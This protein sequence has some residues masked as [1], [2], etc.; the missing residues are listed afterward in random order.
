MSHL[1]LWVD[2]LDNAGV[3]TGE[4]PLVNVEQ[5]RI[6]RVLDGA[7]S[8]T[9]EVPGTDERVARL[10]QNERRVR[11]WADGHTG[12]RMIGGGRIR[13]IRGRHHPDSGW[14]VTLDGPDDLDDLRRKSVLLGREHEAAALSSVVSELVDLADWGASTN[15]SATID[16]RF[17]GASVLKALQYLVSEQGI[18]FRQGIGPN[19]IE[20]GV[21]GE[22]NGITILNAPKDGVAIYTDPSLAYIEQIDIEDDSEDVINWLIPLG[23]GDGESALT[24]EHSTRTSPYTIQSLTG[25]DGRTLYYIADAASIAAYGEIQKVGTFKHINPLST[26]TGDMTNAANALYDAAAAWLR[27]QAVKQTVYNAILRNV[28]KTIRVGDRMHMIYKGFIPANGVY[29][30]FVD[31]NDDLWVTK[32]SETHG[33]T[34]RTVQVELSTIDRH[35]MDAARVVIGALEQLEVQNVTPVMNFNKDSFSYKKEIDGSHDASIFLYITNATLQVNRVLLR[36]KSR[37]FRT[38]AS[39]AEAGGDHRHKMFDWN[40]NIGIQP[41][42]A[43]IQEFFCK[44][45]ASGSNNN[46]IWMAVSDASKSDDLWTFDTSGTHTHPLDYSINDDTVYPAGITVSVN[47]VDVTAALG[48]PWGDSATA[49]D[50]ELDLTPYI[51]SGTLQRIHEITIG[52]ASSQGEI[53]G[54][55]EIYDIISGIARGV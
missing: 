28:E 17:D 46:N 49:I 11:I 50:V 45:D 5:A 40:S 32:V 43:Y 2:V 38:L 7:G 14:S 52:C 31:I 18:H 42:D 21:F 22:S 44:D 12:K 29:M 34:G 24:L 16:T 47:G 10:A 23:G 30:P 19:T 54:L 35:Q 4:G 41:P 3:K 1:R 13:K 27:R 26:N 39:G 8:I 33:L 6:A 48:G 9:L 55:V 25:P 37:P 15:F 53:E 20:V 36:L 51:T